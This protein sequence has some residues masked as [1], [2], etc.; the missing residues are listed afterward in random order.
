M[1]K[2][3]ELLEMCRKVLNEGATDYIVSFSKSEVD[4]YTLKGMWDK[5]REYDRDTWVDEYGYE[6]DGYTGD[7]QTF[8]GF[9]LIDMTFNSKK[10][11]GD[12][13][14]DNHKKW[15]PAIFVKATE[16]G[17]EFYVGGGWAST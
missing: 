16:N 1:N 6:S 15:D 7:S 2:S 9:K 13:I 4:K 12:W 14:M 5:V 11:A 3:R 10:E 8:P 17:E